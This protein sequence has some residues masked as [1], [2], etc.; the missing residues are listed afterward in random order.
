MSAAAA[1]QHRARGHV[2]TLGGGEGCTGIHVCV[3]VSLW[4]QDSKL[5]TVTRSAETRRSRRELY[6]RRGAKETHKSVL[7]YFFPLILF[8]LCPHFSFTTTFITQL[9][10]RRPSRFLA[11]FF[12]LSEL[13]KC[14]PFP[15]TSAI[16]VCFS[17]RQTTPRITP[18][19]RPALSLPQ[20]V[21]KAK[22]EGFLVG[23]DKAVL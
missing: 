7:V 11:V 9:C 16:T 3:C 12:F 18:A 6:E 10:I 4:R 22:V 5:V 20:R 15:R 17:L 2:K 21:L 14:S 23:K 19:A 13:S 8:Y 1:Q